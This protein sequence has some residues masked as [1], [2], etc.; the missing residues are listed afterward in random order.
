MFGKSN[1][2]VQTILNNPKTSNR[3]TEQSKVVLRAVVSVS[4]LILSD[5]QTTFPIELSYVVD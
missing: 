3:N 4:S 2:N 1:V 5:N